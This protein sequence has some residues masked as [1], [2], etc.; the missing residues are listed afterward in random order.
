MAE[1]STRDYV[2]GRGKLYFDKFIPGTTIPTGERYLGNSPSVNVT[3]TYQDLPHYTSDYA[4]REMDDNFTL[5]T[6]RG[7]TFTLDNASIENVGLMFGSDATP[8]SATAATAATS[9]LT[10]VK[11]GYYYQIGTSEDAPDGVGSISNVAV[12]QG[13]AP[14][15]ETENYTVD[16][17]NGRLYV[18]D[19]AADIT[20]GDDLTVTYDTV[21]GDSVVVIE[22][23]EQVEGSLRF[24][25]D[26]PKGENKNYFW[27][28]VRIQPTGDFALKGEQWQMMT[29]NFAVLTPK[30]GRKRV[31]IRQVPKA[32]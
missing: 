25:A 24:I 7:G 22:E 5:Q 3:S 10:D 19:D 31:Y 15:T 13:V 9:T 4:V 27:P 30:D 11:L 21:A 18:L 1:M 28:Y 29:F 16:L 17:D 20:E 26:N 32:A 14:V 2:I 23:G 6:D 8:D 12:T